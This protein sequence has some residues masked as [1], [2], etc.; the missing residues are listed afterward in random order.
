VSTRRTNARYE[1]VR[2]QCLLSNHARR[3]PWKVCR[4][5]GWPFQGADAGVLFRRRCST[6]DAIKLDKLLI[7]IA[8]RIGRRAMIMLLKQLA[9]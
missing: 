7:R 2:A 5:C 4:G 9:R 1:A 8:D 3:K 6:C